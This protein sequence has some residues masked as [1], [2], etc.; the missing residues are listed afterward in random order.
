MNTSKSP[1]SSPSKNSE[2]HSSSSS[3]EE[4]N[5]GMPKQTD[6]LIAMYA[7]SFEITPM[8]AHFLNQ[9]TQ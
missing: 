1:P 9:A 2:A 7:R 8:Q 3:D 6:K 4:N 5:G